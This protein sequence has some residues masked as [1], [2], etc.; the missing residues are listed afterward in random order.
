MSTYPAFFEDVRL[1][2]ATH[3]NLLDGNPVLAGPW[4]QLFMQVQSPRHVLSELLQNADDAGATKASVSVD[5][6]TFLFEHNGEDFSEDH[7]RSLCRFGYSNK[8]ILHTIG[9]RGI[10][11]KSTFSLGDRV[12]LRTP[13]LSVG[14]HRKRFTEPIWVREEPDTSGRT[15]VAVRISDRRRQ[16]EVEKNL[17]EWLK[18][19][20]SLLFF[21]NIRRIR[22]GDREL[23]WE[24]LGP[25]PVPESEWM[26]LNGDA[27]APHLSVRSEDEAFPDEALEEI[28]R[29]RVLG[30]GEDVELPPCKVEIVSGAAGRFYV[31]LPTGVET[32]LPFACNA[33]F[34]QDPSR[35]E[36][37]SPDSSPTNRWLLQRIGRLAASAMFSWLE[38]SDMPIAERAWSYRL[39]PDVDRNDASLQGVC[40]TTVEERFG[41]EISGR[42]LL[43]TEAGKLVPEK[44]SVAVPGRLFEIW[45]DGRAVAKLDGRGRPALCRHVESGDRRKLVNW[46]LVE[47]IEKSNFLDA[48]LAGGVPKPDTWECLLKLWAYV[49]P[50]IG[51]YRFRGKAASFHIVPVQGQDVLH[52]A[53]ETVRLGERKLLSSDEDWEFLAGRLAAMDR[54]WLAFLADERRAASE[55]ED[56]RSSKDLD[57]AHAVLEAMGLARTSDAAKAIEAAAEKYFS[58]DGVSLQGCVRLAQIAAKLDARV[59]KSFRYMTADGEL[60]AVEDV[61]LFDMDGSLRELIPGA[62]RAQKLLHSEYAGEYSSCS[63]EEWDDWISSGRSGL[64]S[65]IPLASLRKHI[66]KR[67]ALE[68]E[69]KRRGF[70]RSFEHRYK[71]P[72]F[73]VDDWDFEDAYWK[74]WRRLADEKPEIWAVVFERILVEKADFWSGKASAEVFEQSSNGHAS[75]VV[76]KGVAPAW[77]LAFR[78]LPCVRD[79]HGVQRRPEDLFRRTPDTEALLDVESFVDGRLDREASRTLLDLVGVQNTPTGPGRLLD[80]LRALGQ[81]E[82]P[83]TEEVEKWYRHLDRML[84]GCSTED[85]QEI[86]KAFR[87]EKLILTRNGIWE[88]AAGVFR[89]SD[90]TEIPGAEVVR[91]SVGDLQLWTRIGV[92]DRPTAELAITWLNDLPV[93]RALERDVVRRVRSLLSTHP[94][95]IWNECRHW[96]NLAAE[97]VAVDGL[98]RSYAGQSGFHWQ[99][100]HR[101]VMQETADL[102]ALPNETAGNAP[103]SLVPALA[104]E[105]E[106]RLDRYLGPTMGGEKK[107]WLTALG[108]ELGR[109]V[110][111][112][113]DDTRRI[114]AVAQRLARTGLRYAPCLEIVP[115][116][117]G[118]PAGTSRPA[119]VVWLDDVLYLEYLPPAKQARRIPEEIGKAFGRA[120]IVAALHYSFERSAKDV[121]DYMEENFNLSAAIGEEEEVDLAEATRRV[122]GAEIWTAGRDGESGRGIPV[123]VDDNKDTPTGLGDNY[124][125]DTG[126]DEAAD[127]WATGTEAEQGQRRAAASVKS[128]RVDIMERF[129]RSQGFRKENDGWFSHRDGGWIARANG[130]R[131]PWERY[132][133]DGDLVRYYLPRE[134]CLEREPLQIEADVWRLIEMKPEVY[135]LILADTRGDPTEVTGSRLKDMQAER[136]VVLYPA[137]YRLVFDEGRA[138]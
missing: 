22:I 92:A 27:D 36:I 1:E 15:R 44:Q 66:G 84:V 87:S 3:W 101:W 33:P 6:E 67:R 129:A 93:G 119:D 77:A 91:S 57:A 79:R 104:S 94:V 59:G 29:E 122:D 26:A 47:Q 73:C 50:D 130:A 97:W 109:A 88:T 96:L 107:E 74:H 106:D 85:A 118:V 63:Q 138:G 75:K 18:S 32:A 114:H 111:D 58:R 2:A 28:R 112:T 14:F 127:R 9:F 80:R 95:R 49:A 115:Y 123:S 134:H 125:E 82:S 100:L 70:T 133:T 54:D 86:G 25:G 89:L 117:D 98:S 76:R 105:V 42:A 46:G 60:R 103:F 102:G 41:E 39:L 113:D 64:H 132:G 40:G 55:R 120:D 124:A 23:A 72:F 136:Q 69:L 31:V 116:I 71:N 68:G 53:D 61:V 35:R 21:R 38:R 78:E 131:F 13:T 56:A 34:I 12:E 51:G 17:E 19:P 99:H 121:R 81:A 20:V 45:P 4:H 108:R 90:A 65:F 5:G 43:L 128:T 52:S 11:F 137:T 135:A 24:S 110:F 83:P 126:G 10:G 8:R 7:F 16:G 30:S 48:L 62:M 37:K